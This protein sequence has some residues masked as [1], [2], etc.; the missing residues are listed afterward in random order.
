MY[1][2]VVGRGVVV[3][4]ELRDR[5]ERK[6]QKLE[7]RL[8]DRGSAELTLSTER[9]PSIANSHVAEVRVQLGA[10]TLHAREAASN[11]DAAID[12]VSDRILQAVSRKR[13]QERRHRPHHFGAQLNGDGAPEED[14]GEDDEVEP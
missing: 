9:N 14:E 13:D 8:G 10:E 5:A 1:L 11:I 7:R 3:T 6:L 4:Q 12:L 2:Q